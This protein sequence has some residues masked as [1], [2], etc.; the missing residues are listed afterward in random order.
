VL[1]DQC[2]FFKFENLIGIGLLLDR[3]LLLIVSLLKLGYTLMQF[4]LIDFLLEILIVC[5]LKFV[6]VVLFEIFQLLHFGF[7]SIFPSSLSLFLF[8]G[9]VLDPL[10]LLECSLE[11]LIL[12]RG[13]CVLRRLRDLLQCVEHMRKL[14]ALIDNQYFFMPFESRLFVNSDRASSQR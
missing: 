2:H 12:L 3:C 1:L 7:N 4:K 11:K 9:C 5:L 14:L 6:L 13:L 10:K 8:D